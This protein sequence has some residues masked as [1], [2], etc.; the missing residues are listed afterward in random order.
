MKQGR[1]WEKL[2]P[3]DM[4]DCGQKNFF[5]TPKIQLLNKQTK[6]FIVDKTFKPIIY[7]KYKNGK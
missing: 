6:N 1:D 4:S 7:Q 3:N 2:F 5:K